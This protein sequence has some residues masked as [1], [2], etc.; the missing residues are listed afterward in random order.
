MSK[1][2]RLCIAET[3]I[4]GKPSSC[5]SPRDERGILEERLMAGGYGGYGPYG[6]T[7]PEHDATPPTPSTKAQQMDHPI[8][9]ARQENVPAWRHFIACPHRSGRHFTLSKLKAG[10]GVLPDDDAGEVSEM[11][12][13]SVTLYG[14]QDVPK[15][16][17]DGVYWWQ[18]VGHARGNKASARATRRCPLDWPDREFP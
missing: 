14:G 16:N 9:Q 5:G 3:P 11:R 8:A 2:L 17:G 12:R 7:A 4:K 18:D 1:V 13:E 10:T 6:S 15:R